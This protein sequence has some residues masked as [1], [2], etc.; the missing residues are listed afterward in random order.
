MH[1]HVLEHPQVA[2]Y[3]V[4]MAAAWL[5]GWFLAR[6]RAPAVGVPVWVIDGLIPLLML[7][8]LGGARAAGLVAQQAAPAI[9]NDYLLLGGLIVAVFTVVVVSACTG[10]GLGRL[11]DCFT[12]AL[13]AGIVLLRIGCLMAG[14]C[15]GTTCG[16]QWPLAVT[17]PTGSPAWDDQVRM[18]TLA[19]ESPRS[20]RV[21]PVPLYEAVVLLGLLGFS[22]TWDARW[23]RWGDS[24][25]AI[26]LGYCVLR[27][28]LEWLRADHLPVMGGLAFSQWASLAC[29]AGC[30]VLWEVRRRWAASGRCQLYRQ[31]PGPTA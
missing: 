6:R 20:L 3:G 7:G 31:G 18:G 15:W 16:D 11:G 1:P 27:F 29:A 5:L 25:L 10:I 23:H 9:A 4:M 19:A 2:S 24:F 13:P 26:A 30:L 21:H 22:K 14:C 17:Y 12:Y 8:I 28:F